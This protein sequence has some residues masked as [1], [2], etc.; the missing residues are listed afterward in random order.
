MRNLKLEDQFG[1][2]DYN[3]LYPSTEERNLK[4]HIDA[5]GVLVFL[6]LPLMA[7][8]VIASGFLPSPSF[9]AWKYNVE[10]SPMFR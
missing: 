9:L 3:R 1:H 5:L 2:A 10:V 8:W 7:K 6:R 4:I